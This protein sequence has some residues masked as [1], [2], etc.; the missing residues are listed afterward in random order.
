MKT[1]L[2]TFLIVI[3]G[4]NVQSQINDFTMTATDGTTYNLYEQLDQGKTIVLDFFS[5]TCG[6]CQ[7]SVPALENAWNEHLQNGT[8]GYI[9]SIETSYRPDTAID[10]FFNEYGGSFPAFSIINDDSVVNDTFGYYVPY[11]P[12]FYI[13]C[14]SYKMHQ[15][16]ID[17]ID[18]FLAECGVTVGLEDKIWEHTKIYTYNNHLKYI[19]LPYEFRKHNIQVLDI[20]GKQILNKNVFESSGE[21]KLPDNLSGVF[22]VRVSNDIQD[23]SSKIFIE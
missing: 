10:A 17:E 19:D 14:P 20:T 1:I 21:I 11:T 4:L 22:L 5:T 13:I 2:L 16:T 8:Y 23:F 7:T 6:T 12:Y 9:W 18:S 3:A 15:F